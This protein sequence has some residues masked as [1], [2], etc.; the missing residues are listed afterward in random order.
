MHGVSARF[1]TA[2][3]LGFV[4][5]GPFCTSSRA[6]VPGPYS[7][8]GPA[9]QAYGHDPYGGY[10]HGAADVI[11]AQGQF[12]VQTQE[13]YLKYQEF[14]SAKIDVRR[15][16]L[17]QWLWERENLPTAEDDR[18]RYLSQQVQRAVYDPPVTE[19]W[20]AVSLNFLLDRAQMMLNNA[21]GDLPLDEEL[22]AK[23][24]VTSGKGNGNVGLLRGGKVSWPL[25]L[26]REAFARECEQIDAL[27]GQAYKQAE[28]QSQIDPGVVEE[29]IQRVTGLQR[30]LSGLARASG[31]RATWTFTQYID[32]NRFL[33]QFDD[34]IR[35]LQ[36]KDGVEFLTGKVAARGKTVGELIRYMTDN[37]LHFAPA[38]GNE[39]AY[40]ALH[41]SLAVYVGEEAGPNEKGRR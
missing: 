7:T 3:L 23:I 20:S 40:I 33:G 17:E 19:I 35:V 9:Y 36:Q 13:A 29:L 32:A 8:Y 28:Q 25:L 24:N 18:R 26:R 37:G 2:A 39:R 10:L 34:A 31:D 11:R 21:R 12:L 1:R 15:K 16:Q 27:V 4:L 30:Q 38:T 6:Q 41:R 22:V 14:R 5:L